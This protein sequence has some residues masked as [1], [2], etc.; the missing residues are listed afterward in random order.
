L[1]TNPLRVEPTALV[2]EVRV[3]YMLNPV[4]CKTPLIEVAKTKIPAAIKRTKEKFMNPGQTSNSLRG[5]RTSEQH[6]QELHG[7]IYRLRFTS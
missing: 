7:L 5:E 6:F 1:T 3:P 2:G 4:I